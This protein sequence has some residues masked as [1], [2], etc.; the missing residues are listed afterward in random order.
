MTLLFL[1]LTAC[2]DYIVTGIE[3]REA[4]ILVHP[5]H[6]NF[7]HLLSGMESGSE[8]FAVINTG[9]DDLTIFA[10]GL[11]S[12]N[13][14]FEVFTEKNEYT[15]P[16]G[17]L[18]EFTVTY[19]PETFESNGGFIEIISDDLDEPLSTVIIEGYGDAPV[20]SV[21]PTD[22]DYGE[23]S[24]G[25]DNEERITIRNDGNV[26]LIIET[27]SQMVTQ[28]NDILFELGSLPAPPW[29]LVPGMEIDFL[30][31]YIPTDI[32]ADDS[33]I[34]ILSTDPMTPEV[35][36]LQHGDGDVEQWVQQQWEQD[37]VPILDILWVIDD[38]GSMYP[39]Q[40]GLAANIGSFMG[41]FISSGA[42]YR[43]AVITTGRSTFGTI[44]DQAHPDAE[45]AIASL[46][47]AGTGGSAYERG[48]QMARD[49]LYN[50]SAAPG[51]AFFRQGSKLVVIFVSDEPDQSIGGW[52]SFVPF[53]NAI[54]P[55]GDFIPYAVIGDTPSGCLYTYGNYTRTAQYG[56]GYWNL[57]DHYGG[58]WYSICAQDWGVQLQDL[59]DEVTEK[60]VFNLDESDPIEMTI[61]VYVNGQLIIEW[62]YDA[63]MNA[64]IFNDGHVPEEGQTIIIDY[65][66][67]GCGSES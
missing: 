43:M 48:I 26:D 38:S 15:I 47:M 65:A 63:A 57:V 29:I 19:T 46:I 58:S 56:A 14:R 42:D 21:D 2:N 35:E 44:I 28:P 41:A 11:I 8:T 4:N 34:T 24:I 50:G 25:C 9:D 51:G 33:S 62:T 52:Y 36:A 64:V 39:F 13:D 53:F 40:Q 54:K 20:I 31:S 27:V 3:K 1:L 66:L 60:R 45:G 12:G 55:L 49:S 32:G 30:V 7:G 61:E 59:A 18:Q 16:A 37:E 17:E 5:T 10:P 67:W 6:L 23:I 22:V